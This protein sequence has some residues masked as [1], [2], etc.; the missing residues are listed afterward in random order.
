[1]R[2][3]RGNDAVV[4]FAKL[5]KYVLSPLDPRGKHKARVFASALQILQADTEFLGQRLMEAAASS[6]A[7]VG[8]CAQRLDI[9]TGEN[10]PRLTTC[11][12]LSE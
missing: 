8:D 12:V 9:L 3:P 10:F 11:Y 2:L 5:R 6:D 7:L 1:M 4:D